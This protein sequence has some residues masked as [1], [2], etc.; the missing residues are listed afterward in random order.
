MISICLNA[1]SEYFIASGITNSLVEVLIGYII[2]IRKNK[3]R[4]KTQREIFE[5]FQK[6][7]DVASAYEDFVDKQAAILAPFYILIAQSLLHRRLLMVLLGEASLRACFLL[8]LELITDSIR[9][10]IS[11]KLFDAK[12]WSIRTFLSIN[13]LLQNTFIFGSIIFGCLLVSIGLANEIGVSLA[14]GQ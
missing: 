6:L 2:I 4:N 1:N 7:Q 3:K 11:F 10:A 5:K 13:E 12:P 8:L 9:G 14:S